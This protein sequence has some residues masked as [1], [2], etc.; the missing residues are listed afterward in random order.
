MFTITGHHHPDL[1]LV[2]WNNVKI[3]VWTHAI[4]ENHGLWLLI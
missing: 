2:G 4:G 1:L 3:D